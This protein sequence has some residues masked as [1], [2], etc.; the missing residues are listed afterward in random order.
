MKFI[1][2]MWLLSLGEG[3]CSTPYMQ[4]VKLITSCS[5]SLGA[6]PVITVLNQHEPL[7]EQVISGRRDNEVNVV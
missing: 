6:L 4:T 1:T 5:S 3:I 7:H 2:L